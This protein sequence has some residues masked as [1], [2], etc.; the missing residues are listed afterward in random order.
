[1]L[2]PIRAQRTHPVTDPSPGETRLRQALARLRPFTASEARQPPKPLDLRP[3]N[4]FEVAVAEQIKQ[5]R[6]E[7]D[8]LNARLWW[9]IT[10][11]VGLAAANLVLNLLK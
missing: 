6:C 10:V 11:V 9:L 3:S 1:M 2:R 7:I 4:A 8:K 5:L